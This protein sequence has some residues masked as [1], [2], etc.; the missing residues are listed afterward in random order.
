MRAATIAVRA[1]EYNTMSR[2]LQNIDWNLLH[3][4]KRVLVTLRATLPD[5]SREFD[6]LSGIIHLLDAI[7]DEAVAAGRWVFP[8]D[9]DVGVI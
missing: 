6:A 7:Q 3:Q 2:A 1:T 8:E 4:Q 5:P 9:R